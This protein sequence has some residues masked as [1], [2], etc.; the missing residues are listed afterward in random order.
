MQIMTLPFSGGLLQDDMF[1]NFRLGGVPVHRAAGHL[2]RILPLLPPPLFLRPGLLQHY[3][4]RG[5]LRAPRPILPIRSLPN[6]CTEKGLISKV[7]IGPVLHI[8]SLLENKPILALNQLLERWRSVR[9]VKFVILLAP[10]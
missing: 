3:R 10:R 6:P 1:P 9:V 5:D 8:I 4:S 7:E 2:L